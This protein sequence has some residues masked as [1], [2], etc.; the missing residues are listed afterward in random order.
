MSVPVEVELLF[1]AR[2]GNLLGFAQV[3]ETELRMEIVG[4]KDTRLL[5]AGKSPLLRV[6]LQQGRHEAACTISAASEHDLFVLLAALADQLPSG[7]YPTPTRTLIRF[8]LTHSHT[9]AFSRSLSLTE[10]P[11]LSLPYSHVCARILTLRQT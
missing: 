6:S 9:L 1:L 10:T 3:L 8:P 7:T 2:A 5:L 11:T 4:T